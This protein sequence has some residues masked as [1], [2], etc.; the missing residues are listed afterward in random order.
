[1][2]TAWRRLSKVSQCEFI[3]LFP[4]D[5]SAWDVLANSVV[6]GVL[7]LSMNVITHKE[8]IRNQL[9][10]YPNE[11]LSL[12]SLR[13]A[14]CPPEMQLLQ[15]ELRG[16][17]TEATYVIQRYIAA[18]LRTRG[19]N[20]TF[21][22]PHNL[23]QIV[24]TNDLQRPSL[25]PLTWSASPWFDFGSKV[26]WQVQRWLGVPY[27]NVFANYRLLDACLQC[28]PG[29]NLVYERNSL[30]R[31]GVAMACRRLKLPYVLYFEADDIMEHDVMGKPIT[32]LLR[33]RAK[34]A[35]RYNLNAA[36]CVIC[37][38][39]PLKAHLVSN[40]RVP[41]DKIVVFPNVA[42]V[43]CFRPD[44]EARSDVRTSLGVDTQ[45]LVI[46]V[47]NF[48]EWHDVTTLL[49]AFAKV[50][51][52]HPDARLVLVGD[53]SRR[54]AMMKHAANLGLGHAAQFTGL[55]AHAEVPR[56]LA[57]A[58]IAVVPYPLLKTD[59]WLSPLKLFEYMA[60]GKAIIASSVG[61][62]TEVVQDG[63][64]GLLVPPGDTAAMAAALLRL[65]DD[66]ALQ[67]RLGQQAREDAVRQ[68][69][70]ENYLA[71][72]ERLFAAVI[73][74]QPVSQT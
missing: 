60:S 58:D 16:E 38:S 70:W 61:Q 51:E 40:W 66:P 20:L 18:G 25:A 32:G 23:R 56:L 5:I 73:V 69:S 26:V 37:V 45:P 6:A 39:E 10:G 34:V 54:E 52:T 22:A 59:V 13:I 17:P 63:R 12:R 33:W 72:L 62:L 3:V 42:D 68:H 67:T 8:H 9:E 24:C 14:I 30:Y 71:R 74:G 48:Y 35:I 43:Q 65:I 55:V 41:A 29:H 64:N 11:I 36:D 21:L 1:M 47:G 31:Y 7:D 19:H 44:P 27:L 57:A 4:F 46:F 50:R 28:L 2:A 15:K 53:G 49:A